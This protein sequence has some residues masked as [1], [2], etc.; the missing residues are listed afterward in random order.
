MADY[1]F[2]SNPPYEA[3]SGLR[4][5]VLE[6]R[7]FGPDAQKEAD[8]RATNPATGKQECFFCGREL[9]PNPGSPNS[10]QYDHWWPFS[11]GGASTSFNV[12]AT[13]RACNGPGGKWFK[14]PWNWK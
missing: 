13:C 8:A 1:A 4:V 12:E 10:K 3:Q 2:G 6:S 9:D 14:L 7:K 11:K 5:D